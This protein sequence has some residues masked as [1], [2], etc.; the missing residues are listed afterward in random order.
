MSRTNH[1]ISTPTAARLANLR[2]LVTALQ[3]NQLSRTEISN[4]LQVGESCARAY[5][6]ELGDKVAVVR[7]IGR[8]DTPRSVGEPVY[9]LAIA[10][11]QVQAFL[12]SLAAA[13]RRHGGR[14]PDIVIA[15]RQPG[16]RFH[17][18]ADDTHYA[19]RVS[20]APAMR[21]PLVAALFGAAAA[22][23]QPHNAGRA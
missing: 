9:C 13:P 3:V 5:I 19:I 2:K 4:L 1:A 8:T 17:I 21:D 20:R 6:K 18:L 15:A 14:A 22:S 16:R 10:A 23:V 12:V 11:D 7:H